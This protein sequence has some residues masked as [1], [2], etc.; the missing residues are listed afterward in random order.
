MDETFYRVNW[1]NINE[2]VENIKIL[3][4]CWSVL[5]ITI[6]KLH[7]KYDIPIQNII[8]KIIVFLKQN[9]VVSK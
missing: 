5:K 4:F 1:Q 6:Y 2:K 7:H 9:L 3:I 8:L